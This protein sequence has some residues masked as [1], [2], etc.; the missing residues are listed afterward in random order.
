[1]AAAAVLV[2]GM[3]AWLL[4]N[5][6]AWG[7][8]PAQEARLAAFVPALDWLEAN[9]PCGGRILADRRT[10]GAFETLTGRVGILEGPGPYFRI[11]VLR[12]A[13]TTILQARQFLADP[14]RHSDF[15]AANDVAA[16]VITSG[17]GGQLGAYPIRPVGRRRLERAPFLH[18]VLRTQKATV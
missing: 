13:L 18:A 14:L 15:L 10:L 4:P 1:H 12:V 6:V 5:S 16:V 3:G 7:T 17:A 9:V 8:L 11:S 2:V